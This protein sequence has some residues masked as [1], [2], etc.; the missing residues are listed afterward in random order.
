MSNFYGTEFGIW[1]GSGQVGSTEKNNWGCSF[2]MLS[3]AKIKSCI[4]SHRATYVCIMT[5]VE[6]STSAQK[7]RAMCVPLEKLYPH[8]TVF[9]SWK[10]LIPLFDPSWDSFF[11]QTGRVIEDATQDFCGATSTQSLVSV[12]LKSFW[13]HI[14]ILFRV[15]TLV[16]LKNIY[17]TIWK[18]LH[19]YFVHSSVWKFKCNIRNLWPHCVFTKIVEVGMYEGE[20]G[21]EVL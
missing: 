10:L 18:N 13:S 2:F 12:G 16:P 1:A 21:K 15:G 20:K 9:P 3:W 4:I 14:F 17:W 8:K 19:T 11:C 7:R 5:L 6:R